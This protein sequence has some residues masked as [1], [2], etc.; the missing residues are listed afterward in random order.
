M[1]AFL[2]M[3]DQSVLKVASD[4]EITEKIYLWMEHSRF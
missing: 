1:L 2:T 4:L 3:T